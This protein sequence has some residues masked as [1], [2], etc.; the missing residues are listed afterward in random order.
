MAAQVG[1]L[2]HEGGPVGPALA[3][4]LVGEPLPSAVAHHAAEEA[5]GEGGR[6]LVGDARG[7][8]PGPPSTPRQGRLVGAHGAD[9]VGRCDG[10]TEGHV[11][12]VGVADDDGR[13]VAHQR[14]QVGDVLGRGSGRAAWRATVV[15]AP[16]V[17]DDVEVAPVGARS[18]R[19]RRRG[20][21]SRGRAP[22]VGASAPAVV[23]PVLDDVQALGGADDVRMPGRCTPPPGPVAMEPKATGSH[24][25]RRPR[26][27]G[28]I[29][30]MSPKTGRSH[31]PR[32][33]WR[34]RPQCLAGRRHV[35]AVPQRPVVGE[36]E[37]AGVLRRL[38]ARWC[39]HRGGPG[40]R[41]RRWPRR[42]RPMRR[43]RRCAR[44][45]PPRPSPTAAPPLRRRRARSVVATGAVAAGAVAAVA[46]V[47]TPLRGA[48][49]RIAQNMEASLAVPT[50]TSVRTVPGQAPR[51][52]PVDPQPASGADLGGQGEL[53]PPDRLRRRARPRG[54]ARAQ[55]RLRARRRGHGQ[56]RGRA[57][58][59]R[60]PGSG[61]RRRE[62]R[63]DAGRCSSRSS[64]RPRPS[65]SGRS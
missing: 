32:G 18:G 61:G 14:H 22:P 63:R 25:A 62:V 7:A 4:G 23:T 13:P 47:P 6:V 16:V 39:R 33:R 15:A 55:R 60:R 10:G 20:R 56:A 50:A 34:L 58:R 37:L 19:R 54:G 65:T 11:A 30:V 21:V 8:A 12:A 31:E 36:R 53:H 24:G 28:R 45:P 57:P 17:G 43:R 42:P 9:G 64:A 52:E 29:E 35:R 51:G 27:P 5:L 46:P 40:R 26:C 2:G 44:R 38:R 1:E 3:A 49:A 41:P 48:A 59:A